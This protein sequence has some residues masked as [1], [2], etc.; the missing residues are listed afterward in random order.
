MGRP[1]VSSC[2]CM[3]ASRI[4]NI[5]NMKAD[6]AIS[7]VL[8]P[9][10]VLSGVLGV[11]D[12]LTTAN[13]V[14]QRLPP[15]TPRFRPT[16]VSAGGVAMQGTSGLFLQPKSGLPDPESVD[17]A[18][19]ASGPPPVLSPAG[20]LAALAEQQELQQWLR[21]VHAAGGTVA[22]CCTGSFLLAAAGLLDGRLATTHWFGEDLFRQLFP[23][24]E[25]RIDSLLVREERILTGGGAK[26]S[27]TLMLALIDQFM[28][29]TAAST[30]GRLMLANGETAGQTA[31]RMWIPRVDHG[32]EAIARAQTWLEQHYTEPF[33]LDSF[34]ARATLTPRTLMRRFKS[35]T[36]M[37]PLQ[38]QQR[39]RIAVAKERLEA[40]HLPVNRIVWDVGY[41]DVSSFQRLF[42]RET[43]LT[44]VEYRQ[45]FGGKRYEI[46]AVP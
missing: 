3:S 14:A 15:E 24:V 44:M 33:D 42:K 20:M 11:V 38:Y 45:R 40:S 25:L 2:A 41:E 39:V 31:Y 23:Q 35:A 26:S 5:D 21:D 6:I 13:F 10:C 8:S 12:M 7:V 32:D 36:G 22:S 43:G 37:A 34:A 4:G 29:S 46:A 1:T 27:S 28:G 17:V 9:Q 16:L 30:T 19:V 18:I